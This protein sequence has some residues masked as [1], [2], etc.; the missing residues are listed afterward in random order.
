MFALFDLAA[1]HAATLSVG[2]GA[3][4]ANVQAAVSAAAAGDVIEIAPGTWT[5]H[6][7]A[8]VPLTLRGSGRAVT[9]LAATGAI[10]EVLYSDA[11]LTVESLTVDGGGVE[12]GITHAGAALWLSDVEVREGFHATRGGGIEAFLTSSV[13]LVDTSLVQNVAPTGGGLYAVSDDI[14]LAGVVAFGNDATTG[15]GGA[16][17][18]AGSTIAVQ[19]STFRGNDAVRGGAVSVSGVDRLTVSGNRIYGNGAGFGAAMMVVPSD[20]A[21]LAFAENRVAENVGFGSVWFR[22]WAEGVSL[23]VTNNVFGGGGSNVLSVHDDTGVGVYYGAGWDIAIRDNTFVGG[24]THRLGLVYVSNESNAVV[25]LRNNI[26]AHCT[27]SDAVSVNGAALTEDYDLYWGNALRDLSGVPMGA[28]SSVADP[29]FFRW[30]D[31]G[32][33]RNDWLRPGAA[34]V[35][36]GDPTLFDGNGTRS[37]IGARLR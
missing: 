32:W 29:T 3:P 2:P 9:V 17:L 30:I 19:S 25:D 24:R 1:A 12:R 36:L 37:D 33:F 18:L 31:D 21:T 7:V 35:D 16:A 27:G 14:L 5:E 13:T 10:D 8:H 15:E 20:F 22:V 11:D 26:F 4:Y 23:D 6:V 28:H 34:A